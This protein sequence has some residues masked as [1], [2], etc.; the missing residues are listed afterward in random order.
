MSPQRIA[1][2]ALLILG[3]GLLVVGMNAKNSMV[4]QMSNTF[5]GHFTDKT[6]WYLLGGAVSG[7]VGL[8]MLLAG[9]SGKNA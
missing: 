7:L 8:V 5:L 3:V 4:D 1:G 9:P 6:T 2:I